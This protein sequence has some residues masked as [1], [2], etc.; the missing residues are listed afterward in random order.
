[1]ALAKLSKLPRFSAKS[2][3]PIQLHVLSK[4]DERNAD[5]RSVHWSD[6]LEEVYYYFPDYP[7]EESPK[8][9][10]P[11]E[12]SKTAMSSI[13]VKRGFPLDIL[14]SMQ[15]HRIVQSLKEVNPFAVQTGMQLLTKGFSIFS[16]LRKKDIEIVDYSQEAIDERWNELYQMYQSAIEEEKGLELVEEWV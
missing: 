13:V 14:K 12:R 6:D 9:L 10:E 8:D 3:N 15:A 11:L 7:V 5:K 1:M 2:L 4:A 16:P